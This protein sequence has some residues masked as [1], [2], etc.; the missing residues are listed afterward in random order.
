MRPEPS[1]FAVKYSQDA[2][3]LCI[4]LFPERQL[5]Q[6]HPCLRASSIAC[7]FRTSMAGF[8]LKT[9]NARLI[10]ASNGTSMVPPLRSVP[11]GSLGAKASVLFNHRLRPRQDEHQLTRQAQPLWQPFGSHFLP[12]GASGFS[13][14]MPDVSIE[15]LNLSAVATSPSSAAIL[16]I[17]APSA[18]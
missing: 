14:L 11:R 10:G 3:S 5:A 17:T 6:S 8:L 15:S 12:D 1:G 2:L 13:T 7:P 18:I 4:I 16:G 9:A